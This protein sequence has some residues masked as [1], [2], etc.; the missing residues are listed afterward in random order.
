[1]Q[2][3]SLYHILYLIICALICIILY[4]SFRNKSI[5]AKK[6]AIIAILF[7]GF[8]IHF[9]KLLIPF[10]K[11]S[12][13]ISIQAIT[14][15]TICAISTLTFPFIFLSNNNKLKD[16]MVAIGIS[17]GL[18]T[19]LV[20]LDI[21]NFPPFNL[22]VIRFFLSHLIIF[23]SGFFTYIF[24][25]HKLEKSWLK[26]TIIILLIMLFIASI[27]LFICTYIF[28]GKDAAIA[29]FNQYK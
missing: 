28:Y 11:D 12:L 7:L 23:I 1:M 10:Y 9:L 20:P 24:G 5:K 14:P 21:V 2:I 19:L 8:I 17:S 6:T 4:F 18:L 26:H 15:E 16:Y 13:P 22:E 3:F 25:I 27:D 29:I